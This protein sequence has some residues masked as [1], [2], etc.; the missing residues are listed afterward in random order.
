MARDTRLSTLV[1][2][3]QA[4]ALAKLADGG[5]VDIYDG[6]RPKSADDP[7]T[8]QKLGV[9]LQLGSPAFL[10]AVNGDISANPMTVGIS[11]AEL[12]KATWARITRADHKSTLFDVSVG[13]R[14][15]NAPGNE[16]IANLILPNTHI[17]ENIPV[18]CS[19]FIHSV[20]KSTPGS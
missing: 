4:D 9:S 5:F 19:S 11:V 17:V 1:V 12:Q 3:A 10:P 8:S 16:P 20:A 6:E 2:N 18:S 15:K 13:M 14:R 7:V